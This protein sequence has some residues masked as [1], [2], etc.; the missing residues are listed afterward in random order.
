M[1]VRK[2]SSVADM[3]GVAPLPPL[4]P[5]NLR[6]AC[7]LTELAYGLRSWHLEPGVRKFGSVGEASSSRRKRDKQVTGGKGAAKG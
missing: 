5:D 4:D 7:E 2:Y 1:P 6:V 3:P